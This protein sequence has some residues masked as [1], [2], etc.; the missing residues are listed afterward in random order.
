MPKVQAMTLALVDSLIRKTSTPTLSISHKEGHIN[1][2]AEHE[3]R[4]D[5]TLT[6]ASWALCFYQVHIPET[7]SRSLAH[8]VMC[9]KSPLSTVTQFLYMALCL[10]WNAA[11]KSES[12]SRDQTMLKEKHAH[13]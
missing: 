13:V 9:I 6:Q 12:L 10:L 8:A 3:H 1:M 4:Q 2:Q 11:F 7:T 5:I